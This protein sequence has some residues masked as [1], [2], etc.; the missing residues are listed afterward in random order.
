MFGSKHTSNE[1]GWWSGLRRTESKAL[2]QDQIDL[3]VWQDRLVQLDAKGLREQT[4][5]RKNA[6]K[7]AQLKVFV[8][9]PLSRDSRLVEPTDPFYLESE[10]ELLRTKE[11]RVE[12][13]EERQTTMQAVAPR[14]DRLCYAQGIAVARGSAQLSG[15]VDLVPNKNHSEPEQLSRSCIAR[16]GESGVV[17]ER[18]MLTSRQSF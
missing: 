4:I 8:S 6:S 18:K 16:D 2:C 1:V 14:M 10:D 17:G 3:V 11:E 15:Y 7:R 9:G 13:A 12:R 5:A